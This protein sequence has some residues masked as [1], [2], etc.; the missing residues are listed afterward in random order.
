M[1]GKRMSAKD[2]LP[3]RTTVGLSSHVG[4]DDVPPVSPPTRGNSRDAAP[5]PP[6]I[7]I[8]VATVPPPT[9]CL[10]LALV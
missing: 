7:R 5:V 8:R 10:F 4:V 6:P 3:H 1:S 9:L 2:V